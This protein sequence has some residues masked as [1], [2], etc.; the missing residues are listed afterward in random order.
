MH[1]RSQCLLTRVYT[2]CNGSARQIRRE[3]TQPAGHEKI[4]M[5]R[6]EPKTPHDVRIARTGYL[7]RIGQLIGRDV[8][9][10]DEVY[11]RAAERA[12]PMPTVR[13]PREVTLSNG[14]RYRVVDGVMQASSA[15]SGWFASTS[16]K[17]A[18]AQRLADLLANPTE[19]RP[20]DEVDA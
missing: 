7:R 11:A 13:V 2:P 17:A 16:W 6:V 4:V 1:S 14:L 19:E 5:Q 20:A 10:D 8:T 12:F 9:G 3:Q 18:D 15:S